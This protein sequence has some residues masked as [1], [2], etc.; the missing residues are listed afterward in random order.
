MAD[1]VTCDPVSSLLS[2][3]VVSVLALESS[4]ELLASIAVAGVHSVA[5]VVLLVLVPAEHVALVLSGTASEVG[6]IWC[7]VKVMMVVD[8]SAVVHFVSFFIIDREETWMVRVVRR[9]STVRRAGVA[10]PGATSSHCLIKVISKLRH[11][12]HRSTDGV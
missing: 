4:A 9:S 3:S 6:Q 5:S 12:C 1:V 2:S 7:L 10:S 8:S 11:A